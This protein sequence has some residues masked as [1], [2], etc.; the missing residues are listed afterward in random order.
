MGVANLI[1][2]DRAEERISGQTADT[3]PDMMATM[4][5]MAMEADDSPISAKMVLEYMLKKLV[6][7]KKIEQEE[8]QQVTLTTQNAAVPRER[9]G[10]LGLGCMEW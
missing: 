9:G 6:A 10:I 1:R 7:Y 8:D 4:K 5:R 2:S 3:P